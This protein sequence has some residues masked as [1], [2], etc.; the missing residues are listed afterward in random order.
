MSVYKVSVNKE[1]GLYKVL[2]EILTCI[3]SPKN[4]KMY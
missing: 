1:R 2:C 3:D 4:V